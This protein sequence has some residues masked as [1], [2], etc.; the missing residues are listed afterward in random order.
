[1]DIHR[2]PAMHRGVIDAQYQIVRYHFPNLIFPDLR[3]FGLPKIKSADIGSIRNMRVLL[4]HGREYFR[5]GQS[6]MKKR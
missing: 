1:M 2:S 5:Q 4:K 3:I 6:S